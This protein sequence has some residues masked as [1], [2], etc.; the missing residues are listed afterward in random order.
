MWRLYLTIYQSKPVMPEV[1]H[2]VDKGDLGRVADPAEHGFSKKDPAN[3][4]AIE[5]AHQLAIKSG[6]NR[7]RMTRLV[8][9]LIS[10]GTFRL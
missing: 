7:M 9:L 10:L 8:Q 2:Q 5:S 4:H 1:V 3:G 6:F